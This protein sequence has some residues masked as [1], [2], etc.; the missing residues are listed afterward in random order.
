MRRYI[1]SLVSV[2][3]LVA[4]GTLFLQARAQPTRKPETVGQLQKPIKLPP[5]S[6][7]ACIQVSSSGSTSCKDAG[8]YDSTCATASCPTGYSLT[9]GGGACAAGDRKVKSLFPR[10][11]R[12]QFSQILVN[13][14]SNGIRSRR[15]HIP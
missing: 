12:G 8:G 1:M 3:C 15:R 4:F 6:G 2:F 7:L 13:L 10:V 5:T 11:D 9:G 14:A